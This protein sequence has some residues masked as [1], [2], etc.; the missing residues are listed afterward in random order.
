MG[1][2]GEGNAATFQLPSGMP[3]WR[4]QVCCFSLLSQS[5]ACFNIWSRFTRTFCVC[6][7]PRCPKP[8]PRELQTLPCTPPP[9]VLVI[10]LKEG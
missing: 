5:S 10:D 9:M 2:A 8:G 1:G 3:T 4:C 6:R 7:A